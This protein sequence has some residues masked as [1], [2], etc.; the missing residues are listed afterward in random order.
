[1]RDLKS[2]VHTLEGMKPVRVYHDG[3]GEIR[4]SLVFNAKDTIRNFE[5]REI[6]I[7]AHMGSDVL[8]A[9]D[10][11]NLAWFKPSI[12]AILCVYKN[13]VAEC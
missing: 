13:D 3:H 12:V 1:M 11:H 9:L 5:D 10:G 7:I 6:V 2:C 8:R 4:N